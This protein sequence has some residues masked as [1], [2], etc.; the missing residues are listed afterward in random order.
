MRWS[1]TGGSASFRRAVAE[2]GSSAS[3][4]NGGRTNNAKSVKCAGAVKKGIAAREIEE[5]RAVGMT[6]VRSG[7]GRS[8]SETTVIAIRRATA[9]GARRTSHVTMA[10]AAK[11]TMIAAAMTAATAGVAARTGIGMTETKSE[12]VGTTGVVDPPSRGPVH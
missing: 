1:A 9:D 4:T 6:A 11:A 7:S 10:T 8:A 3:S 5:M 12:G 2:G